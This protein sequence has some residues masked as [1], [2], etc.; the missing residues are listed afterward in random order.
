MGSSAD[1]KLVFG[2]ELPGDDFVAWAQE[3]VGEQQTD[4]GFPEWRY[5]WGKACGIEPVT[6][7]Y[8]G[9]EEAYSEWWDKLRKAEK[10]SGVELSSFGYGGCDAEEHTWILRLKDRKFWSY[11]YTAV[12]VPI[13]ELEYGMKEIT[14]LTDALKKVGLNPEGYPTPQWLLCVSYG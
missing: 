12:P 6:L 14:I 9:N 10:E 11:D 2:I 3:Y 4:G 1:A 5:I 8:E 13:S 7:P